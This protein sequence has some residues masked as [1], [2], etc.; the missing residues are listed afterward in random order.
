MKVRNPT[1]HAHQ[2]REQHTRIPPHR[3][4]ARKPVP[5]G[6]NCLRNS[7]SEM[8]DLRHTRGRSQ[9]RSQS[10]LCGRAV[11]QGFLHHAC[12]SFGSIRTVSGSNPGP[13]RVMGSTVTVIRQSSTAR[14]RPMSSPAHTAAGSG[15]STIPASGLLEVAAAISASA[16]SSRA[17]A[18]LRAIRASARQDPPPA[19]RDAT[20]RER[21]DGTAAPQ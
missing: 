14:R 6:S 10:G 21:P 9:P 8:H 12:R 11:S 20:T 2:R 18:R 16:R 19:Q 1:S 15:A 13:G 17:V 5:G 7:A 4:P 3:S